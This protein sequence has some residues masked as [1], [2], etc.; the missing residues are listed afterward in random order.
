MFFIQTL[1][2]L[3]MNLYL[4]GNNIRQALSNP[5]IYKEMDPEKRFYPSLNDSLWLMARWMVI[6]I[7]FSIPGGIIMGILRNGFGMDPSMVISV[8]ILVVYTLPLVIIVRLGVRR[9]RLRGLQ[10]Y[11]LGFHGLPW[12][13]FSLILLVGLS[14]ILLLDPI[15]TMI[16]VTEDFI[17]TYTYMIRPDIFSFLSIVIAA[18]VL[19]EILFR[20]VIL[21]GFLHNYRPRKAIL[22]SALIFGG[23]HLNLV[24]IPGAFLVGIFLGWVYWKTRTLLPVMAIHFANNLI[25]YLLYLREGEMLLQDSL[26]EKTAGYWMAIGAAGV[27]GTAG[28]LQLKKRLVRHPARP[29]SKASGP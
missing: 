29:V 23:I 17:E 14:A 25:S 28:F 16:P 19:E 1:P 8:F 18:P 3:D 27:I 2:N 21:E 15:E 5:L 22:L 26:A 24:Q 13:T 12:I 10:G 4:P 6:S 9:I 20:G 11:R 7:L